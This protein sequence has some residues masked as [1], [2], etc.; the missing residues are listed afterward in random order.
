MKLT[1]V[2]IGELDRRFSK[3]ESHDFSSFGSRDQAVDTL[4]QQARR[5]VLGAIGIWF[6]EKTAHRKNS[7][8][9]P[10]DS[11]PSDPT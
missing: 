5:E 8:A 11:P 9:I 7:T 3:S 1:G 10:H 6:D 4:Y 2:I